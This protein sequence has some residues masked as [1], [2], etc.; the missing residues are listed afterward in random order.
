MVE[1][2]VPEPS[3]VKPDPLTQGEKATWAVYLPQTLIDEL[4]RAA[5]TDGF[6]SASAYA[7]AL[8]VFALRQ[9]EAERI[10]DRKK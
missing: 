9:R 7:Q 5:K 10:A 6:P 1:R 8:L 3:G 4:K 2:V